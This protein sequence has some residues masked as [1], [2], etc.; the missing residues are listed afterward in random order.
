VTSV[1]IIPNFSLAA[2]RFFQSYLVVDL[3]MGLVYYRSQV[4]LLTG[5]IHH[6]MYIGIVEFAIR[7]SWTHIFCLCAAM[8]VPTFF[9]GF[10]TLHPALRSNIAFGVAFFLTRIL[11]HVVIG[12]SYFL[13]DNR[14]QTIGGSYMPS[15]LLAIIFPLHA[16]WFYGCIMGFVRRGSTRD[17]PVS[18]KADVPPVDRKVSPS[19]EPQNKRTRRSRPSGRV[20]DDAR[21]TDTTPSPTFSNYDLKLEPS[22]LHSRRF[23]SRSLSL[24]SNDSRSSVTGTLRTKLYASLPNREVVFDYVGLGRGS[25]HEQ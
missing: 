25:V 10:M 22:K 18:T 21:P 7:R 1:R 19:P 23:Y 20:V 5:W 8:E 15:V 16:M 12:V 6:T 2:T 11:F 9:L 13:H 14:T 24:S 4:G 3:A 17:T